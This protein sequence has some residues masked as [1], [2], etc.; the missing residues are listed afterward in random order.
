M[1]ILNSRGILAIGCYIESRRF[2]FDFEILQIIFS[3]NI[4]DGYVFLL[5]DILSI[6]DLQGNFTTRI[7]F[8]TIIA[9]SRY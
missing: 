8:I 5:C 3:S 7:D 6:L 9:S 4:A 1:L 2:A